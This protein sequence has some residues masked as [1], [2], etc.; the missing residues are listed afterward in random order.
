MF[1][2]IRK[3]LTF[4]YL[5]VMGVLFAFFC[6]IVYIGLQG[7]LRFDQEES[8]RKLANHELAD[9]RE[10]LLE[11]YYHKEDEEE[12]VDYVPGARTFYYIVAKDGTLIEGDEILPEVREKLLE[13]VNGWSPSDIDIQY[14]TITYQDEKLQ[15]L[16]TAQSV[17]ENGEFIGTIYTGANITPQLKLVNQLL[18]LL[19]VVG[20]VFLLIAAFIANYMA[21]KAMV[22]IQKA[23]DKQKQFTADASHELRTPLSIVKS[24]LEVLAAEE[25]NKFEPFSKEVFDDC[26]D[27]VN[28]M[29]KLV[30]DLLF[31]ART[32]SPSSV[33][34]K[35]KID[36]VDMLQRLIKNLQPIAEQKSV[37]LEYDSSQ[38]VHITADKERLHQALLIFIDNAMKYNVEGGSV[39]ITTFTTDQHA[40][41]RIKDTGKGIPAEELPYVFDRFYRVDKARTRENGGNGIGLSIAKWIIEAHKGTI[42]VQS[43]EGSGATFSVKIPL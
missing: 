28:R 24:S 21:G 1:H 14:E 2:K 40:M 34:H 36:V 42:E 27:E 18:L 9:H 23:F 16:L 29:Q 25:K 26:Y 11:W 15:F 30:E 37:L 3:Q 41:I 20:L 8:L 10:E 7:L 12:E 35:E 43:V 32:D 39:N 31:L 38:S 6:V 4:L 19:I 17:F 33:L 22:P 13:V 5:I